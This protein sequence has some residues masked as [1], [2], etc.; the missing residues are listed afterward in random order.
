[1]TAAR[2]VAAS[3]DLPKLNSVPCTTA[4][5]GLMNHACERDEMRSSHDNEI[6]R[7]REDSP[8]AACGGI[9]RVREGMQQI[10][11]RRDARECVSECDEVALLARSPSKEKTML[12]NVVDDFRR[13][14]VL[15]LTSCCVVRGQ[16]HLSEAV[17]VK[18]Q[19]PEEEILSRA[20]Y[21]LE[22]LGFANRAVSYDNN[23]AVV[24]PAEDGKGSFFYISYYRTEGNAELLAYNRQT[25][26]LRR[27]RSQSNGLYGLLRA[28]D[29]TI[30]AGG[31][32][33][34]NLYALRPGSTALENL[35]HHPVLI[36]G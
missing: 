11:H 30:Y 17:D 8:V 18:R 9:Q 28:S 12:R 22:D 34:G 31:I 13:A 29:G 7:K 33:P 4:Q 25:K 27:Y 1:M 14:L 23:F 3:R 6:G 19:Q 5:R 10:R 20:Q 2:R 16:P 26:E 24:A 36:L 21:R 35:V 32:N 15:L